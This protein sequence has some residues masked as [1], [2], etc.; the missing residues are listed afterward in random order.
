MLS[1]IKKHSFISKL[2]SKNWINIHIYLCFG[3]R[4]ANIQEQQ[5]VGANND[6]PLQKNRSIYWSGFNWKVLWENLFHRLKIL[7]LPFGIIWQKV[8]RSYLPFLSLKPLFIPLIINNLHVFIHSK[9]YQGCIY[10]WLN[11]FLFT[12]FLNNFLKTILSNT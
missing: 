4:C 11:L 5:F 10:F 12:S 1:K 9:Y 2:R 3:L 7:S 8:F 6:S